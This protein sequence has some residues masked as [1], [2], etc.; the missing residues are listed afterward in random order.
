LINELAETNYH[1]VLVLDDFHTITSHG[2]QDFLAFFVEHQPPDLCLV[3]LSRADPSLPLARLRGR[4]QLEE[5]RQNELSFTLD[6][7]ANFLS[8]TMGIELSRNQLLS[9]EKRIEGWAAGMQ[10]AALSLRTSTDVS[11]FIADFSGGNEFVAD[12]L[13]DEVLAQQPSQVKSFLLQTSILERLSAPLC[14]A[15]MQDANAPTILET[16]RERNLFLIPL[17]HHKEWYR[18]HALFVDL[19]RNRLHQSYTGQVDELYL[20]A[21]QWCQ[22]NGQT[23]P[24]V[25]YA[26]A[27]NAV[28][29]T[30]A[31]IEQSFETFFISGQVQTLRRWLEKL[32]VETKD[33]HPILWIYH[34]LVLIWAGK[35]S[36]TIGTLL[37]DRSSIF[38]QEGY[39][40]EVQTVLALYAMTEG[41]ITEADHLAQNA[42]QVLLPEQTLFCCL[43]ADTLGMAKT[44]QSETL[45]AI[46][47]FERLAKIASQSGYVMFEI[48]ALSHL[49][50]LHLQ[51]GHLNAAAAGYQQALELV[52]QKLGEK[53]P[54]S[55]SILLGLGEI[56]RE[57]SDLNSA[58]RYFLE[59]TEMFAKYNDNGV[60]IAYLSTARVKI[61][62][63]DWKFAQEYL[64]KARQ[65]AHAS[66]TTRINDRLVSQL[67]A[68][69][70]IAQGLIEPAEQWARQ[71]GLLDRPISEIIEQDDKKAAGSEFV[72]NDYLT[73]ARLYLAQNKVDAALQLL[74]S[75]LN[76]AKSMGLNRRV[77]YI[78]VLKTLTLHQKKEEELAAVVLG[79]AIEL[80]EVEEYQQVFCEAGEPVA[81][82]LYQVIAKG[83]VPLYAKKILDIFMENKSLPV[84]AGKGKD[85][86]ESLV[87]PLSEREQEVLALIAA[88]LSNREIAF[89]LHISLSTVKGHTASIYGKLGVNSR[90]QAITRGNYLGI[91][92]Q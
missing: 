38:I 48:M 22:K 2:I 6:E 10:L 57:R 72:F 42:I 21:S 7:S 47:A 40:G 64:E 1:I 19:L 35:S 9:L 73:L 11:G 28:E 34:G 32:P 88:G 82:L 83:N 12:Y 61:A 25:E 90:T 53:S 4:G 18:Y 80:A 41:K 62:Q 68:R 55:G 15:V 49:A 31:L 8:R 20:R 44:L 78:L 63:G 24:A 43:A 65:Y 70:W 67:Q 77:I 87:E 85:G 16:I 75:M 14:A 56:S 37:S 3:L 86:S 74:D 91:L 84:V 71:N 45:A 29:Q 52:V 66:N 17:D 23:A 27:G 76:T 69:L 54:V 5:I 13:A 79:E 26:L 36:A 51:Q 46:H 81:Q 60:P 89:R 39:S 59:S 30:S 50:G 58:L 92:K 33:Q